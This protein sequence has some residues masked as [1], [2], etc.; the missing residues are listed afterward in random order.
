MTH[1]QATGATAPVLIA[2]GG[3]VGSALALALARAGVASTLVDSATAGASHRDPRPIALS[4]GSR[5]ILQS[6]GVWAP[7]A[8]AAESIERIVVSERGAFPKVRLR[9]DEARI[10]AFGH[11]LPAG[12]VARVLDEVL[13]D[14]SGVRRIHA[15][16]VTASEADGEHRWCHLEVDGAEQRIETQLVVAADGGTSSLRDMAGIR[17]RTVAFGQ[18]AITAAVT[19]RRPHRRTAHERFTRDGPLALLPLRGGDLGLVW[20]MSHAQAETRAALDE[21]AFL[22]QLEDWAGPWC[23][24]FT[25][26]SPRFAFPLT[27]THAKRVTAPRLLLVGNAANQ[28]HPVAG[29]GLNLALRDVAR[30]CALIAGAARNGGDAGAADALR[31]HDRA[32]RS[33]R[34]RTAAATNALARGFTADL[35]PAVAIRRTGLA[36]LAASALLRRGFTEAA[37]GIDMLPALHEAGSSR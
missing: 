24:G 35:A 6:L 13:A 30:A 28:L 31:A 11:V 16:R 18:T 15:G 10:E 29:Q 14:E 8:Q 17:A 2:G 36:A 21:R 33:D 32:G 23:G 20:C 19:P 25:T 22:D 12:E 4:R 1:A 3:M 5:H 27:A 34:C 26:T 9:A 37:M 7:V